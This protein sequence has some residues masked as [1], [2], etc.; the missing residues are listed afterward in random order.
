ME[1]LFR[2]CPANIAK[3]LDLGIIS[4]GL[5]LKET[6]HLCPSSLRGHGAG[7]TWNKELFKIRHS[8]EE[9]VLPA[10]EEERHMHTT[11]NRSI[12]CVFPCHWS[13]NIWKITIVH[14]YCEFTM[15]TG[16]NALLTLFYI[17]FL[18]ILG[19]FTTTNKWR[20]WDGEVLRN[21]FKATCW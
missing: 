1:G 2:C 9:I 17:I 18:L 8:S 5:L 12:C 19:L 20:N 21:S 11:K 4:R 10:R 6:A 16:L 14:S 3:L 7:R 15:C 13:D